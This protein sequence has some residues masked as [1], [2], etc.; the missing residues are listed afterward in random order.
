VLGCPPLATVGLEFSDLLD[1]APGPR[2]A[3]SDNLFPIALVSKYAL[4]VDLR[5][6]LLVLG[7]LLFVPFLIPPASFNPVRQVDARSFI[8]SALL[9]ASPTIFS[10]LCLDAR[11][12]L[13]RSSIRLARYGVELGRFPSTP[14][15]AQV[16]DLPQRML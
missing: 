7:D 13:A 6:L 10:R 1:A 8:P 15:S 11:L 3:A 14:H 9:A 16:F 5:P 12:A 4:A 2:F